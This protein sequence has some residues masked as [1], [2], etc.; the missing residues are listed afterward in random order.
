LKKKQHELIKSREREKENSAQD[1]VQAR[2]VNVK[3]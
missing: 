3:A 2:Y 1:G